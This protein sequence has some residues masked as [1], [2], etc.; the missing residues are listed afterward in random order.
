MR[1]APPIVLTPESRLQ[2]ERQARGRTVLMRVA[3]RSRIVLLDADGK[4][5]E[6]ISDE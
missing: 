5:H 1:V 6:Q 3:L 4:Q 2:L